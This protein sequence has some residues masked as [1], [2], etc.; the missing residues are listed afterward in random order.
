MAE[1]KSLSAIREKWTRVTPMRAEDYR[2][3]IQSPRRDWADA[4]EGQK[5]T[6]KASI[7]DAANKDLF[8]KGVRKCGTDKWRDRA[9]QKGPGRFSEGVMVAGPDFEAG[10]A[11]YREVIERLTLPPRF[12]KG[13]PRNILRVS[14]IAAALRERKLQ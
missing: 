8:A 4:T 14:E 3:G 7:I 12:P 11:P 1:I 2:L 13:D 10:F 6:W 5:E 9:L